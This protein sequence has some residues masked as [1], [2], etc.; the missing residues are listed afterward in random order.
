MTKEGFVEMTDEEWSKFVKWW[1][2]KWPMSAPNRESSEQ[3]L[4][5]L[6]EQNLP[7]KGGDV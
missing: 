2:S 5:Y 1:K 7:Q 3:S 4:N 6:E